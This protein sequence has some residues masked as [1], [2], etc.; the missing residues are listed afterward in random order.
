VGFLEILSGFSIKKVT[1]QAQ[2]AWV[3][4]FSSSLLSLAGI[5]HHNYRQSFRLT[6]A[7]WEPGKQES[8]RSSFSLRFGIFAD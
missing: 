6:F 7:V 4:L 8:N 2:N 3:P 1:A 5:R